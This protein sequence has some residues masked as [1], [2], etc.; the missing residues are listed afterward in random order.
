MATQRKRCVGVLTLR[1]ML[2]DV[3]LPTSTSSNDTV[4]WTGREGGRQA[5]REGRGRGEGGIE[6]ERD[7]RRHQGTVMSER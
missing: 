7:E 3:S 6:E 5:G 4:T 2:A 1:V